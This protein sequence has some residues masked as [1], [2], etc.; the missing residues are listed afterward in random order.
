[1]VFVCRDADPA[2]VRAHL[3][4]R[5]AITTDDQVGVLLDTFLDR[6]RAYLFLANPR[7][8]QSDAL[9]T[10]GQIDDFSFD[11]VWN[12]EQT[13]GRRYWVHFAIK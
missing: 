5:E 4:R 6:R 10:D 13:D 8:I 1:M 3:A 12:A 7:G 11:A 2:G 9:L